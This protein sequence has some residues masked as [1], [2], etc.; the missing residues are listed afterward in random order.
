M[1]NSLLQ[2]IIFD[3][4]HGPAQRSF[5]EMNQAENTLFGGPTACGKLMM[6]ER[7]EQSTANLL[8]NVYVS[9][10]RGIE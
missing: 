10:P 8:T 2:E 3:D 4:K 5:Q 6:T 1:K 7:R 9:I